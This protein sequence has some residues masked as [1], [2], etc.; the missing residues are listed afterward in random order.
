MM[1]S[2]GDRNCDMFQ[3]RRRMKRPLTFSVDIAIDTE[4]TNIILFDGP[5]LGL[6]AA[7]QILRSHIFVAYLPI[8]VPTSRACFD[9]GRTQ[10][11]EFPELGPFEQ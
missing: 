3:R 5:V 4:Q 11:L 8:N 7:R 1:T 6:D 9:R 2:F 10:Q